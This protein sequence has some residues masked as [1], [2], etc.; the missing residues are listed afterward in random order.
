VIKRMDYWMQH[1]TR[2]TLL[3]GTPLFHLFLRGR[4]VGRQEG[5]FLFDSYGLKLAESLWSRNTMTAYSATKR[6][7][8]R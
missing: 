7:R 6:V 5:L 4:V 1:K 8:H 2:L 3:I